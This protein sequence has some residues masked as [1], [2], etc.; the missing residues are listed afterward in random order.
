MVLES[1]QKRLYSALI[2]S[3]AKGNKAEKIALIFLEQHGLQLIE[4]NYFCKAGEID[5]IMKD[6]QEIIF[7]EVRARKNKNYGGAVESITQPKKDKISKTAQHFLY[8]NKQ[9]QD[10]NCRF[11]ALIIESFESKDAIEWIKDAFWPSQ[12]FSPL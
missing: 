11:D 9:F 5:L 6:K 1:N 2:M 12:A 4:N 3:K 10:Y 8:Q 7:I